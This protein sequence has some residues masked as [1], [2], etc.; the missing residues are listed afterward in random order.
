MGLQS[1]GHQRREKLRPRFK[2]MVEGSL[3]V[4]RWKRKANQ[5]AGRGVAHGR[6]AVARPWGEVAWAGWL[7]Q[8]EGGKVLG[9]WED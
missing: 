8:E 3:T 7:I 2:A 4:A 6:G 9:D 1:F 5:G